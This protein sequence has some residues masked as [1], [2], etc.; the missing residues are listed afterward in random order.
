M[1]PAQ[2]AL[3]CDWLRA[4]AAERQWQSLLDIAG[5]QRLELAEG[6]LDLLLHAGAL[7]T[8]ERFIHAQWR[9]ERIVWSDVAV[10]QEAVGLRSAATRESARQQ[11]AA[12]LQALGEQ[13]PWLESAVRHCLDSR[14]GET[15]RQARLQ[16]LQALASWQADQ[17][18]GLRQDFA[19]HARG[20]TKAITP[21]EWKW[22]Q[23]HVPLE[24]LGIARFAPL[25]W[26]GGSLTL[27]TPGG[28]IDVAAAG[29]CGLPTRLFGAPARVRAPRRYWLIENRAS[30][31]RQALAAAPG[32]CVVWL[33]GQPPQSWREAMQWLLQ[34]A[35]APADVSCD[36][37]P[38][39][40]AIALA[41]GALW[42]AVGG[43][44]LAG[45]PH[46]AAGLGRGPAPPAERTRP[47]LAAAPAGRP[48]PASHA[49][50]P[51]HRVANPRPQS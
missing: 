8:K 28:C 48:R 16:L 42:H 30:F 27:N 38:A 15:L 45:P 50:H 37:D 1:R 21:T 25:L 34:Q 20:T 18:F 40:V 10:L 23:A 2:Q 5:A 3:L 46:A 39:G 47:C 35:P 11:L 19:Q 7:H 14:Q 6:L 33:P 31:E 13:E 9:V 49:A 32:T 29:L 17:R 12:Q 22:L 24:A 36:P 41:A 44:A 51:V 4:D 43:P 26:L